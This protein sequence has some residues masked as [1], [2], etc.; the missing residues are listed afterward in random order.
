MPFVTNAVFTDTEKALLDFILSYDFPEK[1]SVVDLLNQMKSSKIV[2]DIT[3][4][5]WIMEFRSN[6]ISAG[7]GPMRPYIQIEVL[8][9]SGI[10]PTEF[11]LYERN[12][13]VFE[14]E[15]YNA[16]GSEIDLNAIMSGDISVCTKT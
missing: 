6:G 15:I 8:H 10:A 16:D 4:Y 14:L 5:H 7:Q 2:R 12:G 11:S 9:G 13:V 1:G 3:P